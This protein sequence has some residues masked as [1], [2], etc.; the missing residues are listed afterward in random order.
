MKICPKCTTGNSETAKF[1]RGCGNKL[2]I[3]EKNYSEIFCE[4]CGARILIGS[5]FCEECGAKVKTK[6]KSNSVTHE[7]AEE[8]AEKQLEEQEAEQKCKAELAKLENSDEIAFGTYYKSS[9]RKKEPIEWIVLERMKSKVLLISKYL[10]DV[11]PYNDVV[12][13]TWETC[14]LRKWLNINFIN[15]AFNGAEKEKIIETTVK[16][17]RNE[18]HRTSG[19]NDTKD[20][21]FVLSMDEASK[22]FKVK[23]ERTCKPTAYAKSNG[24]FVVKDGGIYDGFGWWWLRTPGS[25]Q[26]SAAYINFDGSVSN[27]GVGKADKSTGVR[28]AMWIKLK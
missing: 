1:C 2:N 3:Y 9:T 13:D 27:F 18:V 6:N 10:L 23:K 22:Y 16:N 17:K 26:G 7:A 20:K 25:T 11:K 15:I 12:R 5:A 4:E 8:I 19:G 14:T 28:P 21:V 24:A